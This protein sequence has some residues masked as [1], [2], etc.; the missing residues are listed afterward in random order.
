LPTS[1]CGDRELSWSVAASSVGFHVVLTLIA[2]RPE[3]A[4]RMANRCVR[5]DDS[6]IRHYTLS[7]SDLMNAETGAFE[8]VRGVSWVRKTVGALAAA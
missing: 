1:I 3:I 8:F 4:T 6:L 5:I 2:D 7:P